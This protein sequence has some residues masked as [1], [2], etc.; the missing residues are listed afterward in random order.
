MNIFYLNEDP[1]T[2]AHYHC[3]KHVVKMIMETVQ[4]LSTAHRVL[5][6]NEWADEVG[7]VASTH[8]NHP[9]AVWVRESAEN[10]CWAYDLFEA[11]CVEKRERYVKPHS[12][13]KYLSV[14]IRCPDNISF[15]EQGMTP[16]PQCMPDEYKQPNTVQAYRDYYLGEKS[17]FAKWAYSKI[18]DWWVDGISKSPY[19]ST[20]T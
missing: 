9:S 14:L 7:L 12:Y 3:D 18:P 16:P 15:A 1:R 10:Y 8:V 2:A 6:G 4:L 19:L 13:E 11:L 20:A 17:H 5:D